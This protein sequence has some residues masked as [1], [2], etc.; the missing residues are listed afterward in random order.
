MQ[1]LSN[2][3][4]LWN[5]IM[6]IQ[7]KLDLLWKQKKIVG[8]YLAGQINGTT[9]Y[10]EAGAQGIMAGINAGLKYGPKGV[11]NPVVLNRGD[12]YI[13]VLID[14]LVTRG[15]SEPYRMFTSRAEYRLSLR[16]DNSDI[17]L[18]EK[19]YQIGCVSEHRYQL[20]KKRRDELSNAM[21]YFTTV[22]YSSQEWDNKIP[23]STLKKDGF[24]KNAIE[25]LQSGNYDDIQPFINCFKE[26]G[27]ISFRSKLILL[28]EALYFEQTKK[29]EKYIEALRRDEAL[30]LPKDINYN[31]LDY[32]SIEEREKLILFN[33]PTLGAAS[34]ISGITPSSLVRLHQLTLKYNYNNNKQNIMM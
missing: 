23:N 5:M 13:G 30:L 9:G 18:T 26:I 11:T 19:G 14:D 29:H 17:R 25:V 22:Y 34:R 6:L 4:M 10:E 33:P 32:L 28:S 31:K 27:D 2:M 20:F 21:K 1:K 16:C 8:L 24:R 15:T 7:E 3:D 12:A